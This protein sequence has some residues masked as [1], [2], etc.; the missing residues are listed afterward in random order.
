MGRG[1]VRGRVGGRMV[2]GRG[3]EGETTQL[4]GYVLEYREYYEGGTKVRVG[5]IKTGGDPFWIV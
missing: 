4:V 3:S 5:R 1:T 2:Y